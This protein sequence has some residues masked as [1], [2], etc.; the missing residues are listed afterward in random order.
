MLYIKW[1]EQDIAE[2][3]AFDEIAILY[4]EI[5]NEGDVHKEIGLNNDGKLI[6]K[7][8]SAGYPYGEY[9]IFDNQ[10]VAISDRRS[11]FSKEEFYKLWESN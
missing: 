9:G 1:T 2:L 3:S 10:K 4:T 7:S 6:H 11:N 5:D 8:P